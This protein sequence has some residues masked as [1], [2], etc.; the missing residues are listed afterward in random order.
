MNLLLQVSYLNEQYSN[1]G[2]IDI[3]G[4]S[5]SSLRLCMLEVIN[6]RQFEYLRNSDHVEFDG[7]L[8]L[9]ERQ[10]EC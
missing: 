2:L 1:M 6:L 3:T 7:Y 4:F 9:G 8:G 10:I 5:G